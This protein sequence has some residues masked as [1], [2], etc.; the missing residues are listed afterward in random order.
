MCGVLSR[1]IVKGS[2]KRYLLEDSD[3]ISELKF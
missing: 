2:G 3:L 1:S